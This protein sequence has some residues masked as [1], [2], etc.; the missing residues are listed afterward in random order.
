MSD[1]YVEGCVSTRQTMVCVCFDGEIQGRGVGSK[2]KIPAV[3]LVE[4]RK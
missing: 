2:K 3:Y 4:R 1:L